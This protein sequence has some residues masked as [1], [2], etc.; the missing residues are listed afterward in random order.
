M[1]QDRL[2][3]SP[4][5]AAAALAAAHGSLRQGRHAAV[6]SG[7]RASLI[8]WGLDWM[9]G[10]A[11]VHVWPAW[12]ALALWGLASL[13][14][15]ALPR[16]RVAAAD[17]VVS[18]WEARLRRAWWVVLVGSAALVAIATP[19]TVD[20]ALLLLGALWSIAYALYGVVLGDR[21]IAALGGAI[22]ALAVALRLFAPAATPLFGALA[23]GGTAM[24]G[25]VRLRRGP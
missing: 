15:Y 25:V 1:A 20:A 3:P 7:L 24:L 22:V 14:L 18:G 12:L 9:A 4:E 19:P 6:R 17:L 8:L 21:E 5:E 2:T 13:A 23:G 10:Y 16:L 11:L